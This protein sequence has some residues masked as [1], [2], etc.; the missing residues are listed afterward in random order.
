MKIKKTY[1]EGCFVIEFKIFQDERGYFYESF[2][3]NLFLE[4]TGIDTTFVQD[5]VSVSKLGV[6]RGLHM[7]KGKFAQA[8]LISVVKGKILDV[9][10]DVRENSS[11]FGKSFSI[12]LSDINRKQLFVPRGFLH[13]FS[14]LEE[15]TIVSYKCDN[16]YNKE[17]ETGV[18]YNDKNLEIDWKLKN[19]KIIVSEKD[20]KLREFKTVNFFK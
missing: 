18:I 4:K 20:K 14:S 6:V 3:Q 8:K 11:T 12:E 15:N 16:Y 9:V 10:V 1:L 2:N 5:N 17:S 7:Q 19:D 13:G